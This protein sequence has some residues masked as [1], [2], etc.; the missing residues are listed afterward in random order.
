M[1]ITHESNCLIEPYSEGQLEGGVRLTC[2]CFA[3]LRWGAVACRDGCHV[4]VNMND[5]FGFLGKRFVFHFYEYMNLKNVLDI[6]L[7]NFLK[8]CVLFIWVT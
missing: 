1:L 8:I 4:A 2:R 5:E 3:W 7:L 6:K